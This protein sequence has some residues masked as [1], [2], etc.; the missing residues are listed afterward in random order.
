MQNKARMDK[1]EEDWNGLQLCILKNLLA[2]QFS[3][4]IFAVYNVW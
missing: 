3:K 2:E 4:F 1:L